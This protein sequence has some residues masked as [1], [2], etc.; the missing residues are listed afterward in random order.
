ME[1]LEDHS[2]MLRS[3]YLRRKPA[4]FKTMTGL[5]VALFEDLVWDMRPPLAQTRYAAQDRPGRS[6]GGGTAA[7][8][9]ARRSC[10]R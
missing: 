3:T 9:R 10:S 5:T 4:I 2:M 7:C 1:L 8:P 6:A